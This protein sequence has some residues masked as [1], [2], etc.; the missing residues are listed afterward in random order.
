[1]VNF[2]YII[3]FSFFCVGGKCEFVISLSFVCCVIDVIFSEKLLIGENVDFLWFLYLYR[4]KVVWI[5]GCKLGWEIGES[6]DFL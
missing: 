4:K 6:V 2:Y 3:Y 5:V 1:M